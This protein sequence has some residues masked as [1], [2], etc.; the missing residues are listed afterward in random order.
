MIGLHV[1]RRINVLILHYMPVSKNFIFLINIYT[2]YVPTKI[3]IIIII[4]R[5]KK[6]PFKGKL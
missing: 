6:G 4:I 5:N 1:T 2:Y 3:K